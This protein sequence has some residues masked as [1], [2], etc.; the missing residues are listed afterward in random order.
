MEALLILIISLITPAVTAVLGVITAIVQILFAI[1]LEVLRWAFTH[2]GG[3]TAAEPNSEVKQLDER[4]EESRWASKSMVVAYRKVAMV[5]GAVATVCIAA[6]LVAN[7]FFFEASLRW[8]IDRISSSDI[9]LNFEA[10]TGNLITGSIA[11]EGITAR[12]QTGTES[13]FDFQAGL[14]Q[15]EWRALELLGRERRI[16]EIRV[17]EVRGTLDRHSVA[18]ASE[19]SESTSASTKTIQKSKPLRIDSLQIRSIKLTYTDHMAEVPTPLE[20]EVDHLTSEP[21]RSNLA[22]LDVFFR[23]NA[24]GSIAGVEF[25]I[26]TAELGEGRVARW[27]T[28]EIPLTTLGSLMGQPFRWFTSGTATIDVEDQWE[29]GERNRIDMDWNLRLENSEISIPRG[30]SSFVTRGVEQYFA[31]ST[32]PMEFTFSL[33]LSEED[34]QWAASPDAAGLNR[35][36]LDQFVGAASQ[37][38]LP[39]SSERP[40]AADRAREALQR[41]R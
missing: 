3:R 37:A 6:V 15:V 20:I 39:D 21:L 8:G 10:V 33:Q 38:K 22:I 27:K 30:E 26:E 35:A 11:L 14:I 12:N 5:L 4:P 13:D 18:N 28:S 36:L 7:F 32:E 17:E 23:S 1:I 24:S 16:R 25:L 19:G 41:N 29:L 34:L 31:R 40:S 9:E 2:I